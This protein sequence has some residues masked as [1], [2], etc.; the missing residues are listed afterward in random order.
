MISCGFIMSFISFVLLL[1]VFCVEGEKSIFL[2]FDDGPGPGT[3][4][5]MDILKQMD[6]KATFFV[7]TKKVVR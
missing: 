6:I 1:P 7:Y 3:N 4:Q 5:V 2:T